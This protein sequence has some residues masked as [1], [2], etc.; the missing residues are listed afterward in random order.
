MKNHKITLTLIG[1]SI[2]GLTAETAQA[3]FV[4][5]TDRTAWQNAVATYAVVDFNKISSDHNLGT[6]GSF[7]AGPFTL[8][9]SGPWASDNG[10]EAYDPSPANIQALNQDRNIDG[11]TYFSGDTDDGTVVTIDFDGSVTAFGFDYTS[12]NG[13][14][15]FESFKF[16]TYETFFPSSSGFFGVVETSFNAFSQITIQGDDGAWGADNF[17]YSAAPNLNATVPE[18][19]SIAMW[20]VAL[21]S[22]CGLQMRRKKSASHNA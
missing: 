2:V 5:F 13:G 12:F 19:A 21:A 6:S 10:I 11:T 17:S 8:S 22:G 18:P 16:G 20:G 9:A 15:P 4:T 1:L 7:D 14:I 3:G